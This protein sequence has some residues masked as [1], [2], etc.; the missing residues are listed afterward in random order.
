MNPLY[1]IVK[2]VQVNKKK[3]QYVAEV[4]DDKIIVY[5]PCIDQNDTSELVEHED[6]ISNKNSVDV[7]I[8]HLSNRD[9][10]RAWGCICSFLQD[11]LLQSYC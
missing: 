7:V 9:H 4:Y 8:K 3:A 2:D 1:I 11:G 10:N 5:R 6:I